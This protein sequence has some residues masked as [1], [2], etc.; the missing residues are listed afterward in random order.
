MI[1]V[2][3]LG[4][5]LGGAA[6]SQAVTAHLRGLLS[7]P[8]IAAQA[9]C[10]SEARSRR[11]PGAAQRRRSARRATPRQTC[12]PWPLAWKPAACRRRR[13]AC[14]PTRA[15]PSAC[16]PSWS[17]PVGAASRCATGSRDSSAI[18]PSWR[19]T[20]SSAI[21]WTRASW[22]PAPSPPSSSSPACSASPPGWC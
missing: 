5:A 18:F 16:S 3:N 17:T 11:S 9:V 21:H 20:T 15:W 22:L 13:A 12:W 8:K 1:V 2:S 10:L 14:W 6:H 19:W 4:D 7:D